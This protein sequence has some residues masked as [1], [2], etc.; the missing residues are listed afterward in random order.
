MAEQ[1][2][3]IVRQA[4]V[5]AHELTCDLAGLRRVGL[6]DHRL[7]GCEHR[8]RTEDLARHLRV[9]RRREIGMGA[10]GALTGELDHLGAERGEHAVRRGRRRSGGE[11]ACVHRVEVLDHRRIRLVVGLLVQRLDH[12]P[13]ARA[14]AKEEPLR[15]RLGEGLLPR[16]HRCCR[17]RI[18]RGDAGGHH[19]LLRRR[20]Q[21][22]RGRERF[23]A[24]R[25][26]DPHGTEPER[27]EF[28][29]SLLRAR[30][31]LGIERPGPDAESTDVQ[32]S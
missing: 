27:L 15:E 23:A 21:A 20:Q 8:S 1:V 24:D 9:V 22:R 12:V 28:G 6:E 7:L 32:G 11:H 25:L 19:H 18:H 29:G 30:H 13:V 26:G 31:G 3:R 16:L 2:V 10:V 14:D 4:R 5:G 17:A